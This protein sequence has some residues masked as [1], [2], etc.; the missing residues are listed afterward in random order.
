MNFLTLP[1]MRFVYNVSNWE[2]KK[3]A[4]YHGHLGYLD[5]HR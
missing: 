4:I 5:F 2:E 1:Q 3:P